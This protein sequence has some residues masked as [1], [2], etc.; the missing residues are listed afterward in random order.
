MYLPSFGPCI[1]STVFKGKC[2]YIPT[3]VRIYEEKTQ[4]KHCVTI[5]SDDK[6]TAYIMRWTVL[7]HSSDHARVDGATFKI[8]A[9]DV[10]TLQ[11]SQKR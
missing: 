4:V 9:R 3:G 7:P 10:V 8:A 11:A 1:P 5:T 6:V 2:I